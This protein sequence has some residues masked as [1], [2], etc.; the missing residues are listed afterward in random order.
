M[1]NDNLGAISTA[2][3]VHADSEPDKA[4]SKKCLELAR[5]HSMAV[6][7]AKNGAPAEM[8]SG[9]RPRQFP[10][11]ME[12]L[13]KRCYKSKGALGKI[14][15]ATTSY[16]EGSQIPSPITHEALPY[17]HDL[18]VDGFEGFLG[19]AQ[20]H[21]HQYYERLSALMKY[22]G[23]EHE[24]EMLT[25]YVRSRQVFLNDKRKY[26]DMKDR[27]LIAVRSL[28]KEVECWFRNSCGESEFPK[29]AAAWY[30]VTY[31]P[32]YSGSG[33][34]LLSFPWVM[35]DVLLSTKASKPCGN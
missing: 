28:H 15:R 31:H 33:T 4:L 13:E 19:V 1:I 11:F 30:H 8:P 23:V 7:Y 22:Y 21:Y 5:L 20:E 29:M 16:S 2:H 34:K 9:L 3:L 25:G 35:A 17:D 12:R 10:D 32:S 18:Q 27:M 26:E 6:D 14:Y 24:D